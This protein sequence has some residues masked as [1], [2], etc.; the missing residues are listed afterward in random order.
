M[1]S[2]FFDSPYKFTP[3]EFKAAAVVVLAGMVNFGGL[4]SLP[5][6]AVYAKTAVAY[7]RSLEAEL[8]GA[9]KGPLSEGSTQ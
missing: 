8:A 3:E 4:P 2:P 7:V 9:T 1:D 6:A 5:M